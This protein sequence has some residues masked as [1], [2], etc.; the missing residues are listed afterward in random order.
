MAP[1]MPVRQDRDFDV[2]IAHGSC[3]PEMT[4]AFTPG[5]R[6]R[7]REKDYSSARE[8]VPHPIDGLFRIGRPSGGRSIWDAPSGTP[9]LGRSIWDALSG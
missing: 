7:I 8:L 3:L 4:H 9:H 6:A 1:E 5:D 2:G